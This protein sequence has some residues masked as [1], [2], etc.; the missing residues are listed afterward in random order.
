MVRRPFQRQEL[1]LGL[2]AAA[3]LAEAAAGA[4]H[5]VAGHEDRQRVRGQRRAGRAHRV[6]AA[7]AA[8]RRRGRRRSRRRGSR[9]V[10]RSTS[11][12]KPVVRRQSSGMSKTAALVAE[13]LVELARALHSESREACRTRGEMRRAS[14][15]RTSS[16][17]SMGR[18]MRTRPSR[19]APTMIVPSGVSWCSKATSTQAASAGRAASSRAQPLPGRGVR[20]PRCAQGLLELAYARCRW[21]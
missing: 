17:S 2:R 7:G 3:V 14:C 13:V 5:A 16:G 4:Q 20:R 1:R 19:V 18:P 12:R 21:S 10:A 9:A 6:G 11:R 8:R 15:C